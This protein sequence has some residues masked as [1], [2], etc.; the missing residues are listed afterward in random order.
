MEGDNRDLPAY[1]ADE[2]VGELMRFLNEAHKAAAAND[3][4]LGMLATQLSA[5]TLE[6]ALKEYRRAGRGEA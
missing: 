1:L 4:S 6:L 3:D 2:R 5:T